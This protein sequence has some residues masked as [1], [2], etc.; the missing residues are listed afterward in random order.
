MSLFLEDY[1][2]N[3]E[4]CGANLN[5]QDGFDPYCGTWVC[6]GCGHENDIDEDTAVETAECPYCGGIMT[7][8]SHSWE[9]WECT[10][11]GQYCEEDGYGNILFEVPGEDNDEDEGDVGCMAC[12]NPA[13]PNCK[14][15]CPLFDD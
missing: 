4:S 11:C 13:Y 5:D 14:D 1:M 7:H 2:F 6:S 12:G 15:S 10:E 3:C 9:V 8:P